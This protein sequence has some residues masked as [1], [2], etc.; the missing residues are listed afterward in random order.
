MVPALPPPVAGRLLRLRRDPQDRRALH[1][2][3]RGHP[4]GRGAARPAARAAGGGGRL[5]LLPAY[6]ADQAY[7]EERFA[8]HTEPATLAGRTA[9]PSWGHHRATAA[10]DADVEAELRAVARRARSSWPRAFTAAVAAYVHRMTGAAEVV[11]GFPVGVRESAAAQNAPGMVANI[12][13]LRLAVR[14]DMTLEELTGGA[15]AEIKAALR[16]QRYR[17][18]ELGHRLRLTGTGRRLYGPVVNIMPFDYELRF[19]PS[20]GTM[21]NLSNGPVLDLSIASYGGHPRRLGTIG[22]DVD[23]NPALY[24][25][26]EAA[27]HLDRFL[28]LTARLVSGDTPIG[29]A[30]L[31]L[32]GERARVL[33]RGDSLAPRT[34]P[35]SSPASGRWPG[36]PRTPRR[37]WCPAGPG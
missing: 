3:G 6:A 4:A 15:A 37:W 17:Q 21:R 32:P 18:E 12:V 14:G 34:A 26:E 28:H 33:T 8:G 1:R 10:L 31:L 27:V 20:L 29:R 7:W 24:T 36:G 11:L 2:R 19:G 25:A 30:G 22:V 23:A 16:H 9:P 5:P 35:T 13:P